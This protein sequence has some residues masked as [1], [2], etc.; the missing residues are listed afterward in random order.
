MFMHYHAL[1][2]LFFFFPMPYVPAVFSLSLFLSFSLSLTHSH[3]NFLLMAPKNSIPSK[4]LIRNHGFSFSSST[5]FPLD[6]IRFRDEKARDDFFENF[7]NWAIHSE[8][9][10]ILFDFPD[11]P[12]PGA[13]NSQG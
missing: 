6:S 1:H 10:I 7:S 9:Q 8:C 3:F 12:L 11:T 13:F 4:N 2:T 5:P